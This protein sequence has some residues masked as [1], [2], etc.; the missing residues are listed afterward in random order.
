MSSCL[1]SI[2]MSVVAFFYSCSSVNFTVIPCY[3]EMTE[4]CI[5]KAFLGILMGVIR[6]MDDGGHLQLY[7]FV[8]VNIL[9]CS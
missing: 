1:F 7:K 3:L 5:L 4:N 9:W 8:A 2:L 6:V